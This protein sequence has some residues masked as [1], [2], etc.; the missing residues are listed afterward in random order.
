MGRAAELERLY[1]GLTTFARRAREL[2]TELHPGLSLVAFTV[3]SYVDARS[4]TRAADIAADWGLDKSTVSRQINQLAAAGL[5][6]RGAER[7]G[8]RG[9]V[10]DVTAAG[11]HALDEAAETIRDRLFHQLQDW[12]DGDVA[13]FAGL[14]AR[15]NQLPD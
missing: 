15:F 6:T 10:L 8:R 5:I 3:L 13:A 2:S 11:R 14:I 9:Q 1:D 7:P 4:D 12:T